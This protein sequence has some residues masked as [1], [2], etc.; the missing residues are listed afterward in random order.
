ML[1]APVGITLIPLLLL[2]NQGDAPKDQV[3]SSDC[4]LNLINQYPM[5]Q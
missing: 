4:P 3:P 1:N 5:I 2:G